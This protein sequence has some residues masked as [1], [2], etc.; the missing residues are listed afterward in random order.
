MLWKRL[1]IKCTFDKIKYYPF[2]S[3]TC[4]FVIYFRGASNEFTRLVPANLT[5]DSERQAI[6]DYLIQGWKMR[7]D[8]FKSLKDREVIVV[9]MDM[10]RKF[11]S[12]FMVTYLPT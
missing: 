12:I 11:H 6:G 5:F 3:Q 9:S 4:N 8:I 2:G 10:Y 1:R 7:S